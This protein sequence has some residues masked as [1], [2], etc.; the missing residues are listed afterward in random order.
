MRSDSGWA[1][2]QIQK[3]HVMFT[4]LNVNRFSGKIKAIS[5]RRIQSCAS[6][7]SYLQ[8]KSY[9]TC[10]AFMFC[11]SCNIMFLR[12]FQTNFHY[13][14]GAFIYQI[15]ESTHYLHV[16]SCTFTRYRFAYTI[17]TNFISTKFESYFIAKSFTTQSDAKRQLHICSSMYQYMID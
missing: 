9:H 5:A 2:S 3:S 10:D 6:I 7:N 4:I 14:Q 1:F 11:G 12:L 13:I 8:E 17:P 15:N 16:F